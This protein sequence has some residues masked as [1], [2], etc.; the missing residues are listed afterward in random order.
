M[1]PPSCQS[2]H[3][4]SSPQLAL[5]L[6]QTPLCWGHTGANPERITQRLDNA[7]SSATADAAAVA[8]TNAG[9]RGSS[10]ASAAA[11]ATSIVDS[12]GKGVGA[13]AFAAAFAASAAKDPADSSIVFAKAAAGAKR[14][15]YTEQFGRDFVSAA[16][17]RCSRLC[18]RFFPSSSVLALVSAN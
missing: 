13:D 9:S 11:A 14:R 5:L 4:S 18:W 15:G 3:L 16:S 1:F 2:K 17:S 12:F 8:I 7:L 10:S 6:H